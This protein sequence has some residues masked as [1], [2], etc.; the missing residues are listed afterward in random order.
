M[1]G[2]ATRHAEHRADGRHRVRNHHR[3]RRNPDRRRA[4]RDP[5]DR[6]QPRR[7]RRPAHR[8]ETCST[9]GVL[10]P[11]VTLA[12][13]GLANQDVGG[14]LGPNTLA[15]GIHG[16][17]HRGPALHDERRLAE[18]DDRRRVGRRHDSECGRLS[19]D[20]VRYVR[21][22]RRARRPAACGSTSSPAM[23]ATSFRAPSSAALPTTRCRATT[24]PTGVQALGLANA[25]RIEKNWDFNPGSA[26]R[27]SRTSCGSICPAAARARNRSPPGMFYNLNANNPDA[28]T[29]VP[30]TSRP[31]VDNRKLG[32]LQRAAS[33]CRL[34][35]K[36]KIGFLY[37]IQSNCVCPID[38]SSRTSR[39]RR[40]TISG[41][42]CSAP[43]AGG[44][45]L[46]G[47][48]QAAARSQRH[49]PRRAVGRH[50]PADADNA[51]LDPRMIAVVDSG[52]ARS[53]R[54]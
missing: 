15:L 28:W 27:S 8:R 37:N 10:I 29:Y 32:G 25:G 19:G 42:R 54:A 49:P 18:H 23:A 44:L 21:G 34:T 30:D 36:N 31:A 5:A 50:A 17:Q 11:G 20:G 3:H 24:T 12:T 38:A 43:I 2:S 53:A 45:D 41:S 22:V 40:P 52:S 46:A 51:N 33:R 13:G 39:R 4:E 7:A 35:P 9:L 48:Q 26:A 14:A 1:T 47:H 6:R 16:S